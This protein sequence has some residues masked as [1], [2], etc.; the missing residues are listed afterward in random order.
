[1]GGNPRMTMKNQRRTSVRSRST[2]AFAAAAFAFS[3]LTASSAIAQETTLLNDSLVGGATVAICPCFAANEEVAVW[4]TSPCDGNI[5]AIQIFWKSQFGGAQVTL[6]ESINVYNAGRYPIPGALKQ[7][8]LAPQMIDGGLNEYR[9][10]DE[11]QT[12]P[13]SIPV[14]KDETFVVSLVMFNSNENDI[15]AASVASDTDGV[16]PNRNAVFTNNFG[17]WRS[18]TFLGVSGDWIIRAVVDCDFSCPADLNDD[19]VVDGGDIQ[20]FI[21]LFLGGDIAADFNGDGI[22]DL[23]DI[24]S[25]VSVFLAGC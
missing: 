14:T 5:V 6:E 10:A 25:F 24:Q 15:F 3:G 7:E 19:E 13:I 9:F 23:G 11:N 1:M 4:L 22:L 21:G 18:N 17:G 16:T 2:A 20:A 8:F 12:I